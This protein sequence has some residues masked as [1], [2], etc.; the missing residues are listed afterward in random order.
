MRRAR[1][2]GPDDGLSLC[3]PALG[4]YLSTVPTNRTPSEGQVYRAPNGEPALYVRT[5]QRPGASEPEH[6]FV[7]THGRVVYERWTA[8]LP[9]EWK[10]ELDP[11]AQTRADRMAAE[12]LALARKYDAMARTLKA[13]VGLVP[14]TV[15]NE[16]RRVYREA[17]A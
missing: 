15:A 7:L 13:A 12:M 1:A 17:A 16:L 10:L 5:E 14:P 11:G 4:L 3:R 9:E 6:L 2:R 8:E